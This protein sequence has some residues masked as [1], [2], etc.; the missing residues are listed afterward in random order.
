MQVTIIRNDEW[1]KSISEGRAISLIGCRKWQLEDA[2]KD[3]QRLKGWEIREA[4]R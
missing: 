3:H 2:M 4:V 1:H